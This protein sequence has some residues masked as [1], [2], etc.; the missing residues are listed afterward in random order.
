MVDYLDP[1]IITLKSRVRQVK[2]LW[3]TREIKPIYEID[4]ENKETKKYKAT[5]RYIASQLKRNKD[6]YYEAP[7]VL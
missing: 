1:T 5:Q 2:T 3:D 7:H 6:I 4:S